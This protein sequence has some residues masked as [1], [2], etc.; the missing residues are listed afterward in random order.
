MT[1]RLGI[2]QPQADK[3]TG[4]IVMLDASEDSASGTTALHHDHDV[5]KKSATGVILNPQPQDNPNDPLNWPIWKRD[6]CLIIIGFQSFIGG[7]QS[8]LL[9]AGMS[10]LT[11]EFHSSLSRVSY[12]VGG[13]ML[14]LGFG[15]VF[16]SPSAVL[17]GKRLVYIVGILL[18][19]GGSIWAGAS[20]S[21]I[22][23][24]L[25]RVMT[26]FGTS[27][28]ESLP[29]ATIAEIYFAHERAYRVGIY[30]MLL[31]GGKN[32]IPLLSGLVFQYLDRHWLFYIQACFLGFNLITTFFFV[33]DTF[34][35]RSPVPSKRSLSETELARSSK[36]YVPPSERPFAFAVRHPTSETITRH[37]SPIASIEHEKETELR[38]S[39]FE[40]IKLFRGKQS[41]DSWWMVALRPFFLYSYPAVLFGSLMYS[42]AVVWLIV[43]SETIAEIFMSEE[44]GYDQLT[45][46]LF[47][48]SP[49]LGGVLGALSAGLISDRLC[50]WLVKKNNGIYEPEFRLFMLIPSSI[51]TAIGLMGFGWSTQVKDFWV[52]PIILFGCLGFGS[53]MTST[54]A[55]T[56]TVDSYKMFAAEALVSFNFL[57]NFLGFVFSLFNTNFVNER[58]ERLS[59]V[60]YGCIQIGVSLFAIPLYIYGKK[61][62]SWTDEKELLKYLYHTD[63]PLGYP[64]RDRTE[65]KTISESSAE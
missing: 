30:T 35:D 17:Y 9:A 15:S 43:I 57:K 63:S 7:G 6:I 56:F 26:G 49:F 60:A 48:I 52:G 44:Y 54:S 23:L 53:S 18:F 32:I 28:T 50:R 47:Y 39:Y 22:S 36:R 46:G 2:K 61:I 31:L 14:S 1:S 34:W 51:L 38:I 40:E 33:P 64:R 62:R 11:E 65:S 20:T 42:L 16:A 41:I 3:V 19:F 27:P 25:A 5:V 4:T 21:F 45:V 8:S 29:S 12:L 55:I 10:K 37:L 58:G 13:F 24:M 59:F